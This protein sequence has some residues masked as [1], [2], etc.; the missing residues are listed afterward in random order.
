M[1][2]VA[3]QTL[4]L[5]WRWLR[6]EW[7]GGEVLLL[8]VAVALATASV[9]AVGFFADRVNRAMGLRAS[10]L[11]AADLVV[12]SPNPIPPDL[13]GEAGGRGLSTAATLTFA[14]VVMAGERLQLAEVKAV[15]ARYPLRGELRV[16]D[17]PYGPER[18]VANGP[19]VGS[20]WVDARLATALAVTVGDRLQ[21]GALELPVRAVVAFEPDRPGE[22]FSIGPRLM[23]SLGDVEASGLVQPGS[24]VTYR[25]LVA[26]PAPAIEA[27][28]S[29]VRARLGPGETLQDVREARPELRLALDRAQRFLGLAALVSVLLAGVAVAMAARRYAERHVDPTALMRCLGATQ[30]MV[31]AIF[32]WQLALVGLL[33]GGAGVL[34]GL[35]AQS[36]LATLLGGLHPGELPAP[37]PTPAWVG[38]GTGLVTLAGFALPPLLR[39]RQVPP[40]RV[41]RRDLAPLPARAW[42]V[43]GSAL[44]SLALLVLWQASDLRLAAYVLGGAALTVAALAG[45]ALALVAALRPL[46]SRV[47]VSW[48]FGLARIARQARASVLQLVAFGLG[49]MMLLLLTLVRGGLVES[50]RERLPA[51]APNY[52]LVNVQPEEARSIEDFLASHGLAG[53]SLRPMV[54]GRLVAVNGRPVSASDYEGDR[55]KRLVEREFNLSWAEELQADN[56]LVAGRWWSGQGAPEVSVEIGLAETLGL[57]LGD[58]LTFRVAG[59]EVVARVE[60][61]RSV[62]WDSFQANFFVLAPPGLLDDFPAT[63]ITSFHL[64]PSQQA[65]LSE[66]VRAFPSVTVLDVEAL[67]SRVRAI[68]EQASLAVQYV[69]GFTLLGGLVVLAAAVQ[70]TLDERRFEAAVLRT[71]GADRRRLVAGLLGEFVTLGAL[72]GLLAAGAAGAIG[73]VLAEQVFDLAYRPSAS[74][75]ATGLAA[76]VAG[77]ALAGL[78]GTRR[79]INHPPLESLR[80][81]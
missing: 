19:P 27:Y 50:W 76:G 14:S 9:S 15:D 5:A 72:A 21:V 26:G 59:Q 57:A 78:I 67:L 68:L 31:S 32:A 47:G 25:L 30:G 35:V 10:E 16:A 49:I 20:V 74:I 24:R 55:A 43:Y 11:L 81:A 8:A 73:V 18:T 62:Q 28:R 39:L 7:R 46:R 33:A 38:L 52:F 41:L 61:L 80:R 29:W 44:V 40:L 13:G 60:S 63:Y 2:G 22:L 51:D 53:T 79:V 34:V 70:A 48:R 36:G 4:R 54:R 64:P 71:L 65:T 58:A 42:A 12:L 1:N 69:F 23:M 45:A 77:V 6:R 3:T 17:A 56:R 66:L 75:W 37:S